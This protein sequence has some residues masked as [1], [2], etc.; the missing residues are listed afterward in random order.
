V[1]RSPRFP[2][3]KRSLLVAVTLTALLALPTGIVLAAHFNDVPNSNP[4]HGDIQVIAD[5]GVTAGCGAGNFCPKDNVTR[6]QMAAFM[7][8]LGA[9]GPGKVPVVNADK[10]DG[11]DS[12]AFARPMFAV[13]NTN[14][15]L[16]HGAGVTGVSKVVDG[17]FQVDFNRNVTTCAYVATLGNAGAGTPANGTAVTALRSGTTNSVYV[18]TR[19]GAGTAVD[20]SFHLQVICTAG[21]GQVTVGEAPEAPSE[22]GSN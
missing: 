12:S 9:L 13:V 20:R 1:F 16:A 10:L 6:E 21:E 17:G 5:A 15:T 8:R 7:N 11:L 3:P 2:R 4:F 19:D 14:A 22:P 18:H